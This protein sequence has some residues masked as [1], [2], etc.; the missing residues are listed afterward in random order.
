MHPNR[1]G[2]ESS[3]NMMIQ[4]E[5]EKREEPKE[6]GKVARIG[7]GSIW[8]KT[9]CSASCIRYRFRQGDSSKRMDLRVNAMRKADIGK[10][11]WGSEKLF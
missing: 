1:T 11:K 8:D 6:K 2:D 4:V 5:S 9:D 10:G 3:W 7:L